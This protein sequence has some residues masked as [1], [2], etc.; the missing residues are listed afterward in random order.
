MATF[1]VSPSGD[2]ANPGTVDA[3]FRS[4]RAGV[5]ALAGGDVL[6]IRGGSYAENVVL[7][8]LQ[9]R[10]DAP[11]VIRPWGREEV[12]ID[13]AEPV[14]LAGRTS[15][16]RVAGNAEWTPATTL[17]PAA[18]PDEYVSTSRFS[19]VGDQDRADNG[20]F[21][22]VARHT[23]LITYSRIQDL[24]ATNQAFGRLPVPQDPDGCIPPCPG[25]PVVDKDDNAVP[26]RL[27]DGGVVPQFTHPWVYMGPG[28]L[29]D[30]DGDRR[31]HIRLSH[32]A[33][34]IVGLADYTGATD[35]RQVRLA[36]T[37]QRPAPLRV[38][39]CEFVRL[40]HLT[41]RFGGAQT[42]NVADS[43][44]VLFDHVRVLAGTNG[45]RLSGGNTR[46]TFA[47]CEF[48]GGIP[49]WMFR[50]DI[51][52]GY[53]F[54]TGAGIEL[55]RLG[56]A[57]SDALLFGAADDTDTLIHH[58]EFV[59]G[60]DLLMFGQ[61][62]RFH[63]NL[64]RNLH[65]DALII[66]ADPV[67]DLEVHHNVITQSLMALNMVTGSAGGPRRVHHN[68]ID[69]REP[70]AGIR[71]RPPGHLVDKD[72]ENPDGGVFRFGLL[73]KSEA[74]DGPLD[75]FQNTCLVR[76]RSGRA[77]FQH[78]VSAGGGVRRS[79][80]NVFVDVEPAP[81]RASY[82]TAFL[83]APTFR[84]PTDGNCLH[85]LGGDPQPLL[86]HDPHPPSAGR[87]YADLDSYRSG[88]TTDAPTPSLHFQDSK[89]QYPPGFE[90]DSIDVDPEFRRIDPAGVA[91]FDDDLR[92]R[93]DSSPARQ[94]G[95][96]LAGPDVGIDD[97]FAPPG[98]PD[99]G[100]FATDDLGLRVGVDDRRCFP[101]PRE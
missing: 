75:L 99:I 61:G 32:T 92:L 47:H 2:D 11:I 42:V 27:P 66:G 79:F 55:N 67:V 96:V 44:D 77:G 12:T 76:H 68:L 45:A 71:P 84:G 41:V 4:I 65:D 17:D 53:R 26:V 48:R 86:Q 40:A 5:D 13:G 34:H 72:D 24:R 43:T 58:C 15:S 70:T 37:R 94:H 30:H 51:K 35:P 87:F 63:H 97:P 73:Y 69:L 93:P 91:E 16:F 3:P 33:N 59:D 14:D 83:P 57:T 23:R 8:D 60:H 1:V 100:C 74:P 80:N 39:R 81:D 7:A 21:V 49:T 19:L 46:I 98:N 88:S 78:Y 25:F 56:A 38:Q 95:V 90:A 52:D 50:S 101:E 18:H 89:A 22:D 62:M 31:I 36:I 6:A 85:Q 54:D 9:G 28:V 10:A 64:V 82:S 29:F 20:A